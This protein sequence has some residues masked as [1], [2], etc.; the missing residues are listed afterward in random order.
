M[1]ADDSVTCSESREELEESLEKWRY[2]PERR[3]RR[4]GNSCKA[5]AVRST[6]S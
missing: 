2:A 6:D 1:F 4:G 3:G 5:E